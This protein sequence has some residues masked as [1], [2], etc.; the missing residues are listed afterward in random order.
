MIYYAH[1]YPAVM[2]FKEEFN[3]DHLT[4]KKEYTFLLRQKLQLALPKC[5]IQ[6]H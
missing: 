3:T 1:G 5:C 4:D 6:N 2:T